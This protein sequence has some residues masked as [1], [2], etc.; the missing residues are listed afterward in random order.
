MCY[1][2]DVWLLLFEVTCMHVDRKVS[3]D[4][5]ATEDDPGQTAWYEDE[6]GDHTEQ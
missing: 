3:V 6:P 4:L 5:Q 1:S 2:A